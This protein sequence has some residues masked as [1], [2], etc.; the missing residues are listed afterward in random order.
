LI[1]DGI[2]SLLVLGASWLAWRNFRS[3]RGDVNSA[4]RLAAF[5]FVAQSLGGIVA[6]HHVPA[7]SEIAHLADALAFGLFIGAMAGIFYLALEPFVRRRWPQTLISSTRLL[8]G[9]VDDPLVA[10]HVLLGVAAG[11]F[12]A[13]T[14]NLSAWYRWQARAALEMLPIRITTLDPVLLSSFI[15]TGV[16]QAAAIVMGML[17][18]FMLIRLVLRNTWL[19]AAPIV[20]LAVALAVIGGAP[21]APITVAFLLT[22]ILCFG[23]LPGTVCVLVAGAVGPAPLTWD[24]S[25]WYA[26]RGLFIVAMTLA[27]AVWSF[28]HALGGRKVLSGRFLDA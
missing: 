26:S 6:I 25:A 13:L 23:I 8:S 28:R 2:T 10:G 12:L 21:G 27:L 17:F 24:L 14:G 11:V 18:L 15:V 9:D 22:V 4:A 20:G 3:G 5:G 16:I 7:P 19:A 1:R